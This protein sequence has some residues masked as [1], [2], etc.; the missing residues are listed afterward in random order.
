VNRR[1][2]WLVTFKHT[3]YVHPS[4]WWDKLDPQST[5]SI[6]F[7]K[8]S[9]SDVEVS[10]SKVSMFGFGELKAKEGEHFEFIDTGN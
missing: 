7:E 9:D 8:G 10:G 3:I 5:G 1:I 2:R 6:T 4:D